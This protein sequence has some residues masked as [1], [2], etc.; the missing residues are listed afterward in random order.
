MII[1]FTS[2]HHKFH[3]IIVPYHQQLKHGCRIE[4]GTALFPLC[5][6]TDMLYTVFPNMSLCNSRE[7]DHFSI[8][9]E[10]IRQ[11]FENK[12][13]FRYYTNI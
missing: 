12:Y 11:P 9:M 3:V 7:R 6:G 5:Q 2:L 10:D 13:A 4:A 8:T 1:F